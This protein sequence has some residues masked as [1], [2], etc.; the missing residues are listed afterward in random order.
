MRTQYLIDFLQITQNEAD[1]NIIKR[2]EII[3]NI[4]DAFDIDSNSIVMTEA[5]IQAQ[6]KEAEARRMQEQEFMTN[7]I[8]AAREYGVSPESLVSNMRQVQQQQQQQAEQ[9]AQQQQQ[10]MPGM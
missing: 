8:E 4:A 5:E 2:P 9:M 1:A 7:I 6:Q 10:P 3:R